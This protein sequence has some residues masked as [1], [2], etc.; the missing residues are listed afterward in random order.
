MIAVPSLHKNGLY[1][2]QPRLSGGVII[3]QV[4]SNRGPKN[5]SM[6]SPVDQVQHWPHLPHLSDSDGEEGVSEA[7]RDARLAYA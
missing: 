7:D 5:S 6:D 2:S 4:D 3:N 1:L